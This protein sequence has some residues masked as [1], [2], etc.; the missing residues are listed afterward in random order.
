MLRLRYP[1]AKYGRN[2]HCHLSTSLWSP[3]R[4]IVIGNNVGIGPRC[5]LL[6]DVTIGN[7]VMIAAGVYFVSA[8]EHRVDVIG[9][10]MWDSGNGRTGR[11]IVENDVW[12]GIGAIILGPVTIG[13]GSVVA[14]GSVVAHNVPPYAVVG[15]V[16]ATLLKMRF[17]PAE[18]EEHERLL[19]GAGSD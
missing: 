6:S 9:K 14:A 5:I 7:K 15:G 19:A 10:A 17:S 13:R 2:V 12:I 16:P 4:Q 11:I 8:D 1:W 3:N 18:I